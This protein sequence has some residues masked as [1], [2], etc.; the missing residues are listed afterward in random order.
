MKRLIKN[1]APPSYAEA[2]ASESFA[3]QQDENGEGEGE[4]L[5]KKDSDPA[6]P[7]GPSAPPIEDFVPNYITYNRKM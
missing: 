6:A 2:V 4:E 1:S 5:P 3:W 7:S